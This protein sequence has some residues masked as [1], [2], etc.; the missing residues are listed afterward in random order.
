MNKHDRDNLE[1]L[2]NLE[3]VHFADWYDSIT[4]DDKLYAQEIMARAAEELQEEAAALVIETQLADLDR[5]TLA[6]QVIALVK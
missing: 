5:Y 1:F 6:E 2:L 3:K 4:E